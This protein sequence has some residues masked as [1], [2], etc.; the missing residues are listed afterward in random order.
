MYSRVNQMIDKKLG[1]ILN[2]K[3]ETESISTLVIY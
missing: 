2:I 1:I 3:Q